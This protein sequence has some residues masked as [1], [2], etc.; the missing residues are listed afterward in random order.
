MTQLLTNN[1]YSLASL[2][3][4]PFSELTCL[5]LF[6]AMI[7]GFWPRNSDNYIKSGSVVWWL[8]HRTPDRA[9]S[10]RALA[11][12][13]SYLLGQVTFL[14]KSLGLFYAMILRFWP[15]N[16]DI[17]RAARWSNGLVVLVRALAWPP[18]YLLGQDAFL[19]YF[20]SPPRYVNA[21]EGGG[22]GWGWGS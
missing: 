18:S 8:V 12:P 11:W 3:P 16:S 13:P 15:R 17:S 21:A 2:K 4:W 10:V 6:Y 1:I 22:V 20:F 9:V 14:L 19:L 7:A 5:N